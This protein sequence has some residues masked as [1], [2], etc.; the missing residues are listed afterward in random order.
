VTKAETEQLTELIRLLD[1][2]IGK[3]VAAF[4]IGRL[5]GRWQIAAL[6][7]DGAT[8]DVFGATV[9][10]VGERLAEHFMAIGL[11][12]PPTAFGKPLGSA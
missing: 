8:V 11:G 12:L 4:T 6:L 7:R 9:R 3:G 5:A 1:G 2:E 10:E